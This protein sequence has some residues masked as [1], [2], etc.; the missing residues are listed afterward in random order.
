MSNINLLFLPRWSRSWHREPINRANRWNLKRKNRI[1]FN[2]TKS[3]SCPFCKSATYFNRSEGVFAVL[4]HRIHCVRHR[5]TM[6][7]IVIRNTSIILFDGQRESGQTM[8]IES[9]QSKQIGEHVNCAFGLFKII[10]SK[11]IEVVLIDIGD[12]IRHT[13][14]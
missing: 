2:R 1:Q 11:R 3:D 9:M 6:C 5:E 12:R 14:R 13:A 4:D 7:P 10:V 8:L